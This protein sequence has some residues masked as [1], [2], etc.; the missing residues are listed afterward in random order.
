MEKV[1]YQKIGDRYKIVKMT[2]ITCIHRYDGT[3][4]FVGD[5]VDRLDIKYYH[6]DGICKVQFEINVEP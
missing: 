3:D 1:I 6:E 5:Y 4:V 2:N